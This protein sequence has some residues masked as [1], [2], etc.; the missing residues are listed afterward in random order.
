MG[1]GAIWNYLHDGAICQISG[2]IPGN[3]V[4]RVEIDYLRRRFAEPGDAFDI[5]LYGCTRFEFEPCDAPP[6]SDFA[7]L[8]RRELEILSVE[9][10]APVRVHCVGG[11]LTA[12]YANIA[13]HLDTGAALTMQQLIDASEAYWDEWEARHVGRG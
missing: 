3:V 1:L 6:I 12:E 4:V 2:S 9:S 8:S 5:T 13:P 11:V 10:E 7:E